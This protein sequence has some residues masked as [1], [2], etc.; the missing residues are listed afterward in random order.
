[1]GNIPETFMDKMTNMEYETILK[2]KI[3]LL[4]FASLVT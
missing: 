2:Q 3:Q 4:L 1:M